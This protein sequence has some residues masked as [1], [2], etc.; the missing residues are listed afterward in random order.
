MTLFEAKIMVPLRIS[1]PYSNT[2]SRQYRVLYI[3]SCKSQKLAIS[4]SIS[5]IPKLEMNKE[6]FLTFLIHFHCILHSLVALHETTRPL[7]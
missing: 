3:N 1:S 6:Y 2:L 5:V 7:H 4:I